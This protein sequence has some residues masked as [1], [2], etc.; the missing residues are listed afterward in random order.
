MAG[1]EIGVNTYSYTYSH[2]ALDCLL[3]L[4]ALGYRAFE[5][6]STPPHFWPPALDG[7]A[8]LDIP[9]ALREEGLRI[10]SFN[11][12]SLDHNLVSPMPEMRRY[13]VERF[14]EFIRLAGE[15]GVPWIILVPGRVS[16]LFPAPRPWLE[17]WFGE[18]MR[19]LAEAAKQAGV[20]LLIE[21]VPTA[22]LPKADEVAAMLDALAIPELGVCY[23]VANAAF[24]GED[25]AAG[26]KRLGSRVRVVHLSD[27]GRDRWRHDPVGRGSVDFR[28]FAAALRDIGYK[29]PSMLEIVS[30]T[31]DVDIPESHGRLVPLGWQPPAA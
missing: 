10:L 30:P 4:K 31:P 1:F 17:E 20:Q 6:L 25:P 15:W 13:T 5:I 16:P 7:Q 2:R 28:A 26:L 18:G 3:H 9:R 27:T 21:N 23:D 8:R 11:H 22:W 19:T 14:L 24:I 29:G 12:P